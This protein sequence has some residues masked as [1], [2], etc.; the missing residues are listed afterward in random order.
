[1]LITVLKQCEDFED[2]WN[3][4]PRT[5]NRFEFTLKL[6]M[7]FIHLFKIESLIKMAKWKIVSRYSSLIM[8]DFEA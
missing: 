8:T 6:F 5:E 2:V 4:T 1:M 7:P 3:A